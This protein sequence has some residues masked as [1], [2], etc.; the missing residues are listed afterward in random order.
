MCTMER[1]V[2]IMV[3]SAIFLQLE[4]MKNCLFIFLSLSE[5]LQFLWPNGVDIHTCTYTKALI[6]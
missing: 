6:Q 1:K 2:I 5:S 3:K 4:P